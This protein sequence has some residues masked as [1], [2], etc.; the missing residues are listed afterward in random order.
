MQNPNLKLFVVVFSLLPLPFISGCAL[1][2]ATGVATGTGVAVSEDRRT[3][4][5]MVQDETIEFKS[6]RR[7]EEKFGRKVHVEVT[8]FNQRVLLTGSVI[9]EG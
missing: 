2:A 9:H 1:V 5:T 4:G 8:S 3:A 7:I 6:N